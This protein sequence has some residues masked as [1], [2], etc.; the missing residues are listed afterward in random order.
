MHRRILALASALAL[1]A[2]LTG[3]G[4]RAAQTP[5]ETQTTAAQTTAMVEAQGDIA[6]P[7]AQPQTQAQTTQEAE[8]SHSSGEEAVEA[9][10]EDTGDGVLFQ[11]YVRD[12]VSDGTY[13]M[14]TEQSG[15]KI[16]ISMDGDDSAIESDAAG[17]LRFSL[18]HRGSD[19]YMIMHTTQKYAK[20][21]ESEYKSQVD[22]LGSSALALKGIRYLSSGTETINGKQYRSESFDEGKQGIVTYFFDETGVRRSR[23]VKNGKTNDIEVFNVSADADA[24]MFEIPADYTQVSG[25]GELMS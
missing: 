6:S 25:P 7:Q 13:T 12:K 18:V 2:A 22:S 17:L 8:T 5:T 24:S 4:Q 3:C 1:L 23:V 10:P 20:M 19:Y 11:K 9:L 14:R 21:N 15:V 16:I